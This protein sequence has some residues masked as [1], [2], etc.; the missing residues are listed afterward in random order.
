MFSIKIYNSI[1]SCF[2][3]ILSSYRH[4]VKCRLA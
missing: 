1:I 3:L 4:R 2:Q